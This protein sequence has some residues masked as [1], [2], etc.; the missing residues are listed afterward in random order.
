MTVAIY[1]DHQVPSHFQNET[2][3]QAVTLSSAKESLERLVDQVLADEEPR[4]VVAD[5][6][7]QVVILPL[8]DF[9]AMTSEDANW[10]KECVQC[11][12]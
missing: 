4:I 12:P 2:T 1:L 8:S 6:G 9:N 10:V 5:D 7:R 3:M 11:L